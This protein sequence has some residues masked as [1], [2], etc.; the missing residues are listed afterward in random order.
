MER[1]LQ[2]LHFNEA[3]DFDGSDPYQTY[4]VS[5][6]GVCTVPACGQC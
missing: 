4:Q 3:Q 6:F 2:E 5:F 1:A